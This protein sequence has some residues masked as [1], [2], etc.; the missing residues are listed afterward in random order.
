MYIGRDELHQI[1]VGGDDGDIGADRFG[2][3]GIGGDDIISLEA[4]RLDAGKVESP[5]RFAD[6]AELRHQ[7]FRRCGAVGLVEIIKLVAEGLR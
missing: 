3:P 1:L 2:L 6:Q 7:I 4:F 5:R